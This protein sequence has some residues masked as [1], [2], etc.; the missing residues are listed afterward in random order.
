MLHQYL[1]N[2]KILLGVCGSIAAY[3][4][5]S[6]VRLLVKSQ[7]DVRVVMTAAAT[8]FIA[9]LTFSTLSKNPVYT[10]FTTPDN[11][12]WHSHVELGLWADA[13]IIA[14]ATGNTLAKL[15][16][17]ICNNYLEAVYL[18]ARCPVFFAP[19][20]D[21]DMW[22]HPATQA[23]VSRLLQYGNHLIPVEYGELASGLVGDGRMAE[24]ENIVQYLHRFFTPSQPLK[25]KNVLINAGPTHE[26]LDPV[27]FIGNKSSGKMGIQLAEIAAEYGAQ[28]TLVLGPTHLAPQ[29]SDIAV[30]RVE[31][32]DEMY[33]TMLP[34]FPQA[35]FTICAAAV[36]DFAPTEVSLEKIKKK[37]DTLELV[38]KKNKDIL[39]SLGSQKQP[40]QT[41][42]GFALETNNEHAHAYGKLKR[43]NL[44]F[45]VLNSLK[46]AGAGFLHD[47]NKVTIISAQNQPVALPLL[48]KRDTA[49]QIWRA[50]LSLPN[51]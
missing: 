42:V 18:S 9:P 35:D 2:K 28:V 22:Q 47:T 26:L 13:L 33:Q 32:A 5:A 7:A 21:L 6:L 30:L 41:L 10:Q 16:N 38:L 37:D 4:A 46:D 24:P 49:A 36:A 50:I 31:S 39:A 17:G 15:A 11:S 43:K 27:R 1:K 3:K 34:I 29:Y 12:Q 25:G 45:I 19:A 14:P 23:N 48:S 51:D 44:D 40:N 8:E 20:M